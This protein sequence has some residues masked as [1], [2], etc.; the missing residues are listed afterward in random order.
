[1]IF[2][3]SLGLITIL[4]EAMLYQA[5]PIVHGRW[6]SIWRGLYGLLAITQVI[7]VLQLLVLDWRIWAITAII[8]S[9]R[10]L[11]I[12]RA[13]VWR[14][15]PEILRTVS[16]RTLSWLAVIQMVTAAASWFAIQSTVYNFYNVLAVLAAAQ[17]VTA[18]ALLRTTRQT[19][20]H[21]R[22]MP[23]TALSSQNLPRVSVL[24]PVRNET[25]ALTTCLQSVLSSDYPALEVIVYNDSSTLKQ[26]QT[27]IDRFKDKGVAHIQGVPT[28]TKWL[29]KNHAYQMLRQAANGNILLFC[30]ADVVFKPFSIRRLV[31]CMVTQNRDMVSVLP[32][33]I[34]NDSPRVALLQPM[35]YYWEICF[36]RRFFKRPPVLSTCW[37]IR[38]VALDDF[39]GFAA[40]ASSMTPE[41]YYAKCAVV[42]NSYGFVRSTAELPVYSTKTIDK[43]Y[44]AAIRVRYPQ[45]HRRL[46]LVALT[47]LFQCIFLIGPF[48]G[49]VVSPWLER[50][51]SFGLTWMVSAACIV[52]MYY[53]VA[54]ETHL[55]RPVIGVL[56]TPI[57]LLVDVFMLH[58]SFFKYEFGEVYWKERNVSKTVMRRF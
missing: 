35:R 48:I 58:N 38:A 29:A 10:L 17:L 20:Q 3:V 53:L 15:R 22:P 57:A 13:Y 28:D 33:R 43:Q 54:V 4:V 46:E 42:S 12:A 25:D 44:S 37:L 5:L 27:V 32:Q 55:N 2:W 56:A 19:W 49:I 9:Y 39:G 21:T 45:L 50:G 30:G 51:L 26:T 24:I 11:T 7:T 8:T 31:E 40:T 6:Q 52:A 14:A 18:L 16:L 36:P 1:M 47:A 34:P 41:A 23:V